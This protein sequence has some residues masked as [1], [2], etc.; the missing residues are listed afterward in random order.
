M[1][2]CGKCG[3]CGAFDRISENPRT[4][5]DVAMR[6]GIY[7]GDRPIRVVIETRTVPRTKNVEVRSRGLE[8]P[9]IEQAPM[10]SDSGEPLTRTEIARELVVCSKCAPAFEVYPDQAR[11]AAMF[12]QALAVK[13]S[14]SRAEPEPFR[15]LSERHPEHFKRRVPVP[16]P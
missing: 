14:P 8:H 5:E 2:K 7:P 15:K 4:G 6:D 9:R 12:D 13:R 16:S 3:A 1:F 10:F 11:A